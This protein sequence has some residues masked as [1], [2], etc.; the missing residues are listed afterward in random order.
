VGGVQR[1]GRPLGNVSP[2]ND[3]GGRGALLV[4]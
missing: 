4:C 3:G 2:I 1:R